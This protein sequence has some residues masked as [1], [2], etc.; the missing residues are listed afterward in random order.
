MAGRSDKTAAA[1][2]ISASSTPNVSPHGES[3]LDEKERTELIA[4]IVSIIKRRGVPP[5]VHQAAL[6]LVGWLARRKLCERPC[7]RGLIEARKQTIRVT[8]GRR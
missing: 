4:T 1:V 5:H 6:T 2:V 8:S 3:G 7:Q